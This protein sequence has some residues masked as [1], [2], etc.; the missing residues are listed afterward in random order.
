MNYLYEAGDCSNF[1]LE[2]THSNQGAMMPQFYSDHWTT[3]Y[4]FKKGDPVEGIL[5]NAAHEAE[6]SASDIMPKSLPNYVLFY[7]D[8]NLEQRMKNM[9]LYYPTL[10]YRTTI[11]SGWFDELLHWLNPKNSLEKIH[12]Y[13]TAQVVPPV[14]D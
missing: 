6:K 2:F 9:Q 12:I 4:Y 11:E 13:S 1:I 8:E 14:F 10:D 7:D 3:Y 5:R